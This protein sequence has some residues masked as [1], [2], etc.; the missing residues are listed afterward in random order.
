MG[1]FWQDAGWSQDPAFKQLMPQVILV[2]LSKQQPL[3]I[4]MQI[5]HQS[6]IYVMQVHVLRLSRAHWWHRR[7]RVLQLGKSAR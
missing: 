4:A 3:N 7:G 6:V 5:C 2:I 1:P